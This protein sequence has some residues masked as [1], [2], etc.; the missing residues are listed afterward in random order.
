[1]GTMDA[2]DI[3]ANLAGVRR[4]IEAAAAAS[5]RQPDAV[6]LVAVSKTVGADDVRRALEA[7]QRDFGENQVQELARKALSL[8]DPCTW[9]LI[10]HLQS[11][12]V[13]AAVRT[14]AWIHSVD[15]TAL[16]ER[17]DRICAE[18][19]YCPTVLLQV[20]LSAEPTKSGVP[21]PA[22]EELLRCAL[23]CQHLTCRGL[24]TM[25]PYE[26]PEGELRAVFGGLRELRDRLQDRIG[27]ALPELSMGMSGDFA[28]AIEEGATVVRIGTAIFGP[29]A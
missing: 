24:M 18:E 20:N 22:T 9:H 19:G 21:A 6:R 3:P 23:R 29:R 28:I 27:A 15:S 14:A 7:G 5:G 25:A 10:G 12:K 8:P 2:V 4:R 26:A 1:M 16:L 17:I 13:R 11:N